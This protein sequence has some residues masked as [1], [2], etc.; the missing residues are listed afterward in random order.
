M[1]IAFFFFFFFFERLIDFFKTMNQN[2]STGFSTLC[3]TVGKGTTDE[4][5]ALT[6]G[7]TSVVLATLA[8]KVASIQRRKLRHFRELFFFPPHMTLLMF[9]NTEAETRTSKMRVSVAMPRNNNN[10]HETKK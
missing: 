1:G 6:D 9:Q 4:S 8:D 10:K 3:G 7:E 2:N 5:P